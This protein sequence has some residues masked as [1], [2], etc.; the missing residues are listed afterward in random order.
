MTICET[1]G[2]L[3]EAH[4]GLE[5]RQKRDVLS[6]LRWTGWVVPSHLPE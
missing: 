4:L 2:R 3:F 1:M 6:G 5:V